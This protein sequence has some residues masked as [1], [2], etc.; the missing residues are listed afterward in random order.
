MAVIYAPQQP[1]AIDTGIS[2]VMQ[3][4]QLG[5]MITGIRA[6]K[7]QMEHEKLRMEQLQKQWPMENKIAAVQLW[8]TVQDNANYFTN[9]LLNIN[10]ITSAIDS[11]ETS[12][13]ANRQS[14]KESAE[15]H[16]WQMVTA[17]SN[18][19]LKADELNELTN[20]KEQMKKQALASLD[21]TESS[22]ALNKIYANRAKNDDA[23][24]GVLSAVSDVTNAI[25]ALK[26]EEYKA[27]KVGNAALIDI[28]KQKISA[29]VDNSRMQILEGITK[30]YPD[31]NPLELVTTKIKLN[32]GLQAV[33]DSPTALEMDEFATAFNAAQ[34]GRI[35]IPRLGEGI[36]AQDLFSVDQKQRL[37]IATK[38]LEKSPNV[39]AQGMKNAVD[40]TMGIVS[41]K[42][43]GDMS[44]AVLPPSSMTAAEI[45]KEWNDLSDSKRLA[46]RKDPQENFNWFKMSGEEKPLR[47]NPG[48]RAW[49]VAGWAI[50]DSWG[51]VTRMTFTQAM[52]KYSKNEI[53]ASEMWEKFS[54]Y[55]LYY[56]WDYD[57]T[58]DA[59]IQPSGDRMGKALADPNAQVGNTTTQTGFRYN[60]GN[61]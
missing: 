4:M 54:P 28:N 15:I 1:N 51:G 39:T 55:L 41:G 25:N 12:A 11:N 26:I 8:R 29:L 42:E 56:G 50:P 9:Q 5:N 3:G 7:L 40:V 47:V 10:Q 43:G 38:A 52:E 48:A 53:Q 6:N 22:T 60:T 13:A 45:G 20:T 49:G 61:K 31:M 27:R 57:E 19:K 18:A 16:K 58:K 33:V 30:S 21:A 59:L 2:G 36:G 46:V 14:M 44:Q 24:V 32:A 23:R 17:E 34:T 37:A 35:E